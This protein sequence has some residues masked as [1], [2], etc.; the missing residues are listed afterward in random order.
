MERKRWNLT[1]YRTL[2]WRDRLRVL[3]GGRIY[4]RFESP[5][6]ECNG[7]CGIAVRVQQDWPSDEE[8]WT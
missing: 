4:M 1:S 3:F 8:R 5:N 2:S 7:A 6:G